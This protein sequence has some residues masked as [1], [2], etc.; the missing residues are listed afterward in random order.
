MK[1][2]H[3]SK[4][5]NLSNWKEEAWKSQGFNGI[6]TRDLEIPVQCS[7]NWA[8]KPPIGSEVNF[9]NAANIWIISYNILHIHQVKFNL[10]V[11]LWTTCTGVHGTHHLQP[12]IFY[13]LWTSINIGI[14][15]TGLNLNQGKKTWGQLVPKFSDL[16]TGK[17]ISIHEKH[18]KLDAS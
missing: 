5:S 8:M 11:W 10:P 1:S 9:L 15:I 3:H 2:D 16:V 6:W 13:S 7:T 4:F 17:S 14:N 12:M 18:A